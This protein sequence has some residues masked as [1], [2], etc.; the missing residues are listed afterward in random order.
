MPDPKSIRQDKFIQQQVEEH[1]RQLSGP[2]KTGTETKIKLL[3]GDIE[4]YAKQCIKWP[5]EY[6]LAGNNKDRV[7]YSQLNIT[8][9]M[10][11]EL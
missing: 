6:V 2:D 8:E 11:V 4:A 7:A 1:I 10:A 5:H 3:R 9:W